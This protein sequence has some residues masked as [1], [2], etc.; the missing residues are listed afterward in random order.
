MQFEEHDTLIREIAENNEVPVELIRQILKLEPRYRN[1]HA[2]GARPA[3]QRAL[4]ELVDA[5]SP[6]EGSDS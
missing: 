1:L 6:I 5:A 2:W 4:V 3:L